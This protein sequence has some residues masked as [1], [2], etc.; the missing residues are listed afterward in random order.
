MLVER[1]GLCLTFFHLSVLLDKQVPVFDDGFMYAAAKA[2][3]REELKVSNL[4]PA[5]SFFP[6]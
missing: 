6:E 3:P 1:K 5:M 2:I 4:G